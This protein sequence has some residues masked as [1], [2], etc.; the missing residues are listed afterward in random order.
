MGGSRRTL[1]IRDD[2]VFERRE[3]FVQR[4]GWGVLVAILLLAIAGLLGKGPLSRAT[5]SDGALRVDYERFLHADAPASMRL[6]VA[7]PSGDVVRLSFDQ[8]YLDALDVQ[9]LQPQPVRTLP[10]GNS[11]VMEFPAQA[12]QDFHLS[13]DAMP[14][15][16]AVTQGVIRVLQPAP[17]ATVRIRQ[18]V[19]P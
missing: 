10:A 6:T 11:S 8:A 3:W 7:K 4:V 19:Y 1:D 18:L 13:I 16:S 5:A 12:G 15:S 17:G 14:P 9:R 2:L